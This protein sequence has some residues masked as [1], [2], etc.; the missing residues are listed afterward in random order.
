M[1]NYSISDN[2]KEKK[3]KE[4]ERSV[5]WCLTVDLVASGSQTGTSELVSR[6]KNCLSTSFNPKHHSLP[7]TTG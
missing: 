6:L 7:L 5:E 4:K 1:N 3:L 2:R